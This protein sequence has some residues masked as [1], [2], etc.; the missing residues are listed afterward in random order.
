MVVL[1]IGIAI[2][3]RSVTKSALSRAHS[4][5]FMVAS[6]EFNILLKLTDGLGLMHRVWQIGAEAVTLA[7]DRRRS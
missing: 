1:T 3:C 4:S 6:A 7:R 2:Y 5:Q